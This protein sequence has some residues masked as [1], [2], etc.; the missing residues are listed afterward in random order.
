MNHVTPAGRPAGDAGSGVADAG[1]VVSCGRN[2][3]FVRGPGGDVW[4]SL[5]AKL[6]RG[7]E[8]GRAGGLDLI[9]VGDRVQFAAVGPGEGQILRVEARRTRI[10]RRQVEANPRSNAP[11]REQV[12]VAN[13]HLLVIVVAAANPRLKPGAVDRL[14]LLAQAGGVQPLICVN[15]LDLLDGGGRGAAWPG[16]GRAALERDLAP[17]RGAGY[18]VHLVSAATGEGV[19]PLA[20][21][22]T[23]K[24]SGLVGPSGAGKTSLANRLIPD[25]AAQTRAV[26]DKTGKGRHTTSAARLYE[27]PDGGWL[28][29]TPGL[30]AIGFAAD[31]SAEGL[32]D[33]F[34]EIAAL[35]GGCR[36]RN[37]S[38][39]HEPG[40]AVKA[41]L[42]AGDLDPGSYRR[43]VRVSR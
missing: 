15:K 8:R 1:L 9:A 26:S 42:E 30:R 7:A 38:H 11:P 14:C 21:A 5:R 40:C 3:Y 20:R 25:L 39:T 28:A 18:A 32:A 33:H 10:A 4:C 43:F 22:L 13:A 2:R 27:L 6:R 37:C 29:D 35:A 24:V 31:V 19:D 34:P 36:F 23:G 16:G 41:A 17:F 12:L